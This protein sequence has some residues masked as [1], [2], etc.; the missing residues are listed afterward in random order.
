M[1]RRKYH[2]FS[3][4]LVNYHCLCDQPKRRTSGVIVKALQG[5]LWTPFVSTAVAY[6]H[7][8]P[9]AYG[10]SVAHQRYRPLKI[11]QLLAEVVLPR[12][13]QDSNTLRTFVT[14]SEGIPDVEFVL[15]N[16]GSCGAESSKEG[17]AQT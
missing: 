1:H 6:G 7:T 9:L 11:G 17:P 3:T 8:H 15:V 12:L 14:E 10:G 13:S 16:M 4:H 5:R 2:A